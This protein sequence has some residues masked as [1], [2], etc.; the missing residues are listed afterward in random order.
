MQFMKE[1]LFQNFRFYIYN[2][3]YLKDTLTE[4]VKK[5]KLDVSDDNEKFD[6]GILAEKIQESMEDEDVMFYFISFY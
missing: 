4:H 5:I 2:F 1:F 3:F 6:E